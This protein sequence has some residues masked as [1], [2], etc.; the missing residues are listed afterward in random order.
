MIVYFAGCE[1]GRH[2]LT[3]YEVGARSFLFSYFYLKN[4]SAM[5]RELKGREP[6]INILTDSGGYSARKSGVDIDIEAYR[7]FL[8]D[9][10]DV[11]TAAIN[12]DVMDL[13]QS[14]KNQEFLE[15]VFPVLPVY[16]VKEWLEGHKE[17]YIEMCKKYKYIC[18]G[19]VAGV[20]IDHSNVLTNFLRFCFKHAMEHKV[21]IHGLGMTNPELLKAYPFY[22]VD[23]TSW[24]SGGRYGQMLVW[25]DVKHRFQNVHYAQRDKMLEHNV[26][27][28][29]T[30]KYDFRLAFSAEQILKMEKDIT[31]LWK[32]RGIDF[33]DEV[34][35]TP[36]DKVLV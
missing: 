11:L 29:T 33:S 8:G 20:Q 19:G 15:E 5:L 6:G 4:N 34:W 23:S 3:A 22:S 28:N 16:H 2:R 32:K 7:D 13:E 18:L 21:K 26:P 31:N 30:G 17:M 27:I 36:L 12:L 1:S 10:K 9:A 24:L 35:I 25:D 14:A